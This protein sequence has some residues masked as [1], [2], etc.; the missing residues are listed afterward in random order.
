MDTV[1]KAWEVSAV[2]NSPRI[3]HS[4][5]SDHFPGHLREALLSPSI[6]LSHFTTLPLNRAAADTG[7]TCPGQ[8]EG[9]VGRLHDVRVMWWSRPRLLTPKWRRLDSKSPWHCTS[10]PNPAPLW[11]GEKSQVVDERKWA[12]FWI[13]EADSGSGLCLRRGQAV[14]YVSEKWWRH[15]THV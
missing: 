8:K 11:H 7:V 3:K 10:E 13:I 14:I 6:S 15:G 1:H 5:S 4:Y 9:V 12:S 2:L